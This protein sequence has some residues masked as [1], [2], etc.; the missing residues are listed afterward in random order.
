MQR[1][2]HSISKELLTDLVGALSVVH[3][4]HEPLPVALL[5]IAATVTNCATGSSAGK[6][7]AIM[8]SN[9][10]YKS[11]RIGSRLLARLPSES[12]H[13]STRLLEAF[14][15]RSGIENR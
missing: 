12:A 6:P 5:I 7:S 4:R 9:R 1:R 10:T 14:V 13:G 8:N 3:A 15:R 11:S 2:L